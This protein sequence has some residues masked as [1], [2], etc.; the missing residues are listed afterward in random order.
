MGKKKILLNEAEL[1][2]VTGGII[3]VY[4]QVVF[5]CPY[6]NSTFHSYANLEEHKKNCSQNPEK[7]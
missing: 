4:D 2:Q 5:K 1:E 7:K 3:E 6:C